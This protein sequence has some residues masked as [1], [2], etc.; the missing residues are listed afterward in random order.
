MG[1]LRVAILTILAAVPPLA[2]ADEPAPPLTSLA[3]MPVKEVTVFKDG[4]A[5]VLHQG[6]MPTDPA[7]NVLLDRLPTPVLGTFWPYSADKKTTL[8]SVTAGRR[9]VSVERTVM[10]LRDLIEANPGAEVVVSDINQKQ[11]PATIVG[12]LSRS[13]REVDATAVVDGEHLPQKGNL[14][15]LKTTEGTKVMPIEHIADIRFLGKHATKSADEEYR[16]LLTLQL[17]WG[18]SKP[19]K[20]ADVGMMYLQKGLRWIPGYRVELDGKGKAAVKLQATLINE[21]TDLDDVTA[22]LVVG[23]PSFYFKDTID[24]IALSQS[25]SELS[26]YFRNEDATGNAMSNAIMT[27]TARMREVPAGPGAA[28]PNLGPE[29]QGGSRNEDLFVFT[30]KHIT[31]KKGER[32][33]LPVTQASL[34]YKDVFVLDIP[35]APPPELRRTVNDPRVME[36]LRL[37]HAPKVMH[38]VRLTNSAEQ[39]LTTAPVLIL[40]DDRLLAQGLMTYT[41]R[42]ASVDL[43][44]T[45]A[46]D[47]GVK[48]SDKEVKRTP[49]AVTFEREQFWRIDLAGAITLTNHRQA[50]V[51]VEVNRFVLGNVGEANAEG[52]TEMVNALEDE[53]YMPASSQPAWWGYYSWPIWW[54]RFNGVGRIHWERT[55]EPGKSVD[56]TYTWHY[57]WR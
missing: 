3:R 50:P 18:N 51:E 22:H 47:I 1:S 33:V 7:G 53:G 52:Q 45:A 27:Q 17:D 19:A 5:F 48:K 28:P 12:F 56:L 13:T 2:L 21:L 9:R 26:P 43:S 15:M 29:I 35:F 40:K 20:S 4:H 37:L 30:V 6:S 41:A 55:I 38:K 46:V 36:M 44:V 32:M 42:G 11:F 24:P 14:V 54:S 31:L 34:P 10:T 57:F 8:R 25:L 49:N 39:P 23:V 16:N